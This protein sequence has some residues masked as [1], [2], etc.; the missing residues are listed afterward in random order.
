MNPNNETNPA[1]APAA[2]RDGSWPFTQSRDSAYVPSYSA[3]A[4]A[5]WGQ[6]G[7][8][9]IRGLGEADKNCSAI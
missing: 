1:I 5:S 4:L 3:R 8:G 2:A 7:M 9:R 6:G